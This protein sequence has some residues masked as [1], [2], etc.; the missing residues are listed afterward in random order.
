MQKNEEVAKTILPKRDA[1]LTMKCPDTSLGSDDL[2]EGF[3]WFL[4]QS[5]RPPHKNGV[6]TCNEQFLDVFG[7]FWLFYF[8]ERTAKQARATEGSPGS[9]RGPCMIP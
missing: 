3:L 8:C 9:S 7:C 2:N 1:S 5:T 4:I 6:K